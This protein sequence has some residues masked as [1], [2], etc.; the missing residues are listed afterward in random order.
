MFGVRTAAENLFPNELW[1][2]IR[3]PRREGECATIMALVILF[4]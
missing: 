2:R 1:W 3:P 4:P